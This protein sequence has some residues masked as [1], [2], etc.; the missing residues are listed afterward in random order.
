MASSSKMHVSTSV[1]AADAESRLLALR[2]SI[3]AL[4]GA[5]AVGSVLGRT[6][7]VQSVDRIGL[8]QHL[9][10]QGKL[11][12][13]LVRPFLSAN[14]RSRWCTIRALVEEGRYEIDN[15]IQQPGWD[16][17][18]MV[19]HDGHLY[20]SKP[21][22][23]PTILAGEY[24][25]IQRLTGA[26]LREHPFAIGRLMLLSLNLPSLLA[27]IWVV[28]R[29]AERFGT[30]DFGR[31]FVVA[32]A[33]LGT[34]LTTF[35][36]TLNNHLPAAASAA[37]SLEFLVRVWHDRSRRAAD[38][39]ALGLL[40][41]LT[42]ANELPA[43][44]WFAAVVALAAWSDLRRTL[45]WLAPSAALVAAAFFA[46]NYAAHGSLV[47]AYAHRQSGENWYD[48]TYTVNGRMRESYW[49]NRQGIDRGEADPGRYAW[50][51][52]VGHHGVFSLTPLWLL[53]V[54]GWS[55]AA[56]PRRAALRGVLLTV[57]AVSLICIVFYLA[58]PQM[59]RNYGGMTSGFRWVFWLA[60]LWLVSMLP[61]V[62][63]LAHRGRSAR[64]VLLALLALS[65]LSASYP[66]WNPWT[67]PWLVDLGNSLGW[68]DLR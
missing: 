10:R 47:P 35:A 59:D 4:L 45:C 37:L 41:A 9:H 29:Q 53:T 66:T 31:V 24:W 51:A 36:V 40:A 55:M 57:A 63:W 32:A 62:D 14:D 49:R 17:I 42:A 39:A 21:P 50:H 22:L 1:T 65:G 25:L 52:L 64:V 15:I 61:A 43:L 11:R 18:D 12:E 27:V 58:R 26:T 2:W 5:L 46:A 13:P 3:Y 38:F 6:L 60:P 34:L 28:A 19:K 30:T 54:A 20:S 8:E 16:T 67:H 44:A 33:A 23:L 7:A 68:W 56:A 48:Y